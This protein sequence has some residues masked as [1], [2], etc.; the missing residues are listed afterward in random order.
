MTLDH[1]REI[2]LIQISQSQRNAPM[3]IIDTTLYA[4][5]AL[6]LSRHGAGKGGDILVH[7]AT[8]KQLELPEDS[9]AAAIIADELANG[10]GP[11]AIFNEIARRYRL[12]LFALQRAP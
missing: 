9:D 3:T 1:L 10:Y 11:V 7:T 8:G 4:N 12:T 2:A 5:G 6:R